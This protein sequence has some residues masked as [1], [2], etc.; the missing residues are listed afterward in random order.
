MMT[1]VSRHPGETIEQWSLRATSDYQAAWA[2]LR[3]ESDRLGA[4][5]G[6]RFPPDPLLDEGYDVAM[7]ALEAADDDRTDAAIALDREGQP[8]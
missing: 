1:C 5:Q 2:A 4:E 7:D 6:R 8:G 3:V